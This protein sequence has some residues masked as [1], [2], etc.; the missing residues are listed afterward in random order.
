M[1]RALLCV[2]LMEDELQGD[3]EGSLHDEDSDAG[4]DGVA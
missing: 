2:Q 3:Q 1:L 4:D